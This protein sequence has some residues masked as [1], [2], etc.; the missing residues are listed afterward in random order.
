MNRCDTPVFGGSSL[1]WCG[2]LLNEA[3]HGLEDNL[4]TKLGG[5]VKKSSSLMWIKNQLAASNFKFV[6]S[7]HLFLQKGK[8]FGEKSGVVPAHSVS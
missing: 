6:E 5:K 1:L 7:Q 3:T 8:S 4:K 2:T